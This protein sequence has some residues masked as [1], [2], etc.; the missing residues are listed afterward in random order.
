MLNALFLDGETK[1]P[2]LTKEAHQAHAMN[3]LANSFSLSGQPHRAV[4]LCERNAEYDEG[5]GRKEHL[6]IGL[7]NLADDQLKIGALRAA[8]ANLRRHIALYRE[9]EGEF[10]E[11]IGHAELGRL[12]A[13]RGTRPP[14]VLKHKRIVLTDDGVATGATMKAA[15]QAL[16]AMGLASLIV[17]LPVGPPDTI[18]QLTDMVDRLVCLYTPSDFWSVGSFYSDF[19]QTSDRE[20]IDLLEK[21]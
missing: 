6:A 15:V 11:A 19:S 2:R 1:P 3:E 21:N 8:E 10:N 18:Q 16:R 4:P 20:V 17:A 7:G 13:Y 12:L 9:I 14:I 5:H